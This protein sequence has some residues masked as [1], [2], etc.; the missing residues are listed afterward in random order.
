[1]I[2]LTQQ[3][4]CKAACGLAIL[5]ASAG[6][7]KEANS[8]KSHD[9]ATEPPMAQIDP[10]PPF[11]NSRQRIH[12]RIWPLC[13]MSTRLWPAIAHRRPPDQKA[14]LD[15]RDDHVDRNHESGEHE[16]AGEHAGDVEHAF[17]LLDQIA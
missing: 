16:H 9:L 15:Q 1:M 12:G 10:Y 4:R 7:W 8:N 5:V 13:F 11:P 14:L 3:C 6:F 2:S 17:R